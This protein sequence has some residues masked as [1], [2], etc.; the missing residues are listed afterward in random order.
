MA[1]SNFISECQMVMAKQVL[2][3]TKKTWNVFAV[4]LQ[5]H[6]TAYINWRKSLR[7][8]FLKQMRMLQR[9]LNNAKCLC[10]EHAHNGCNAN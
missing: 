6:K 3:G 9:V 1:Q 5:R 4:I 2:Q 10:K 8:T 7:V